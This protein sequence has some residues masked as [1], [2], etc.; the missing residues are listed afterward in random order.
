MLDSVE[1]TNIPQI[2]KPFGN[3]LPPRVPYCDGDNVGSYRKPVFVKNRQMVQCGPLSSNAMLQPLWLDYMPTR[4]NLPAEWIA[5]RG[6]SDTNKYYDGATKPSEDDDSTPDCTIIYNHLVADY[7]ASSQTFTD[8]YTING[9]T[10][11]NISGKIAAD[12][13]KIVLYSS[14]VDHNL[15]TL[16]ADPEHGTIWYYV[17]NTSAKT[18]RLPN[19]KYGFHGGLSYVKFGQALDHEMFLFFNTGVGSAVSQ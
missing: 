4:S 2:R 1:N 19:T 7:N 6:P 3:D 16:L 15:D 9:S 10:I 13:H 8:S 12:K 17:I 5:A 14:E 18:F 11:I